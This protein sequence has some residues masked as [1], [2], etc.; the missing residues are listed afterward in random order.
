MFVREK[1]ATIIRFRWYKKKIWIWKV[2]LKHFEDD[3]AFN[4]ERRK[5]NF[6]KRQQSEEI[7][8]TSTTSSS[9][10][11]A[12]TCISRASPNRPQQKKIRWTSFNYFP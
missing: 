6:F 10:S 11:S 9:P 8:S 5:R 7:Q 12:S 2:W 1:Y 4:E 3:I